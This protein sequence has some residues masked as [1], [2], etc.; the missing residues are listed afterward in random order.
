[1][2]VD[3][4]PLLCQRTSHIL[5]C[6]WAPAAVTEDFKRAF[7]TRMY[8]DL[9]HDVATLAAL[10][11]GA[12][13][14]VYALN[15][16]GHLTNRDTV[17]RHVRFDALL[18][19]NTSPSFQFFEALLSALQSHPSPIVWDYLCDEIAIQP[20]VG[21][22]SEGVGT[23]LCA[24]CSKERI[25]IKDESSIDSLAER[26]QGDDPTSLCWFGHSVVHC[27]S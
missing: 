14:L 4:Q 3:N 15:Q 10:G 2:L 9:Q 5:Q 7:R 24:T 11:V 19:P 6:G 16:T 12:N 25:I 17:M 26:L 22:T 23:G 18:R 27:S 20:M 8:T 21:V 1:M 13:Q